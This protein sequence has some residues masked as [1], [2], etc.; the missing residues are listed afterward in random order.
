MWMLI[1][2]ITVVI[3]FL[4]VVLYM[5]SM[6]STIDL[7]K[8][9]PGVFVQSHGKI[10]PSPGE[11]WPSTSRCRGNLNHTLVTYACKGNKPGIVQGGGVKCT[12]SHNN[13]WTGCVQA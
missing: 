13:I 12:N 11:K 1:A 3:L 8:P 6:P 2:G 5:Y 9:P 7:H 10:H 4:I